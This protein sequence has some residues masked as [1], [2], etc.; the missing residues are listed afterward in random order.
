MVPIT[1]AGHHGDR[2]EA[3]PQVPRRKTG[4][5]RAWHQTGRLA[6][7]HACHRGLVPLCVY[8]WGVQTALP[9]QEGSVCRQG[10]APWGGGGAAASE[11]GRRGSGNRGA[12]GPPAAAE[13][14]KAEGLRGGAHLGEARGSQV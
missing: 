5:H 2:P 11:G 9:K 8:D 12:A 4:A 6:L 3:P 7:L 10:K 13:P 1:L 14:E